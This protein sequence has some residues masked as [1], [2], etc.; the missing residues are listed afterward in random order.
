MWWPKP[1]RAQEYWL[2]LNK[3][4]LPKWI[5]QYW[6]KCQSSKEQT[7]FRTFFALSRKSS[8]KDSVQSSICSFQSS[9]LISS[10]FLSM[11]SAVTSCLMQL[12]QARSQSNIYLT[13]DRLTKIYWQCLHLY[14]WS[15]I[16]LANH[17]PYHW[18]FE[19]A[20][21]PSICVRSKIGFAMIN[22]HQ[23]HLSA[24][25]ENVKYVNS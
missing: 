12:L 3:G 18:K 8:G 6:Q 25:L 2:I 22:L 10:S 23:S 15:Q 14:C 7:K 17:F 5:D 11:K 4:N 19:N 20:H 21:Y 16:C 13:V 24:Y 1:H 9:S